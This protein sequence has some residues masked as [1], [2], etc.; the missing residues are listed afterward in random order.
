MNKLTLIIAAGIIFLILALSW[1]YLI[2]YGKPDTA[3]ELFAN[4]GFGNVEDSGEFVTPD[5]TLSEDTPVVDVDSSAVQQLTTRPV[6]GYG[7][8]ENTLRFMEEGTGHIYEI[9]LATRAETRLTNTTIPR[10]TTALFNDDA[11][12]LVFTIH[13]EDVTTNTLGT[14]P[15]EGDTTLTTTSLPVNSSNVSFLDS[16]T[17]TYTTTADSTTIA[18]YDIEAGTTAPV[19]LVPFWSIR[20]FAVDGEVI[21]INR[22]AAELTGAFFDANPFTAL[23]ET[24]FGLAGFPTEAYLVYSYNR[25]GQFVNESRD[26]ETGATTALSLTAL[27][28]KCASFDINTLYC[29]TPAPGAVTPNLLKMWYQGADSFTDNLW[30]LDMSSG[31]GKLLIL[32][33]ATTGRQID[34]INPQFSNLK[35]QMFFINKNDNTLWRYEI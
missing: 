4:L 8:T 12:Q 19:A 11:S 23:S 26:R 27:S 17:L 30:S 13:D 16:D 15:L 35:D 22:F 31:T 24:Y 33:E 18:R 34:L 25:D 7:I 2:F 3:G 21:F 5:D 32:L 14:L 29:A 10:V 6:V 9:D 28:E 20:T 1:L